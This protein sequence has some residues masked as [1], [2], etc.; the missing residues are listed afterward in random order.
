MVTDIYKERTAGSEC[1]ENSA[2]GHMIN[3]LQ[4]APHGPAP[5]SILN[6]HTCL[7]EGCFGSFYFVSLYPPITAA[8]TQWPS[9][10]QASGPTQ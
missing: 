6:T 3:I 2:P 5:S 7:G 8:H 9:V 1:W 4:M 10:G